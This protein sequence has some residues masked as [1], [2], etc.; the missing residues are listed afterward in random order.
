[1]CEYGLSAP[2]RFLPGSEKL[3]TLCKLYGITSASS[4]GS[5][6]GGTVFQ[7]IPR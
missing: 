7:V 6:F 1:M 5:Q 4:Y 2:L 3:F